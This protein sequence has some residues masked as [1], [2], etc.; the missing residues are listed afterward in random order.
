MNIANAMKIVDTTKMINALKMVNAP[1]IV[2]TIEIEKQVKC[3]ANKSNQRQMEQ[4]ACNNRR[5]ATN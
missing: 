5:K 3:C 4:I 2:N 1:K